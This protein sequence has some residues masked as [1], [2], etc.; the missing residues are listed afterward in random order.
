L[1]DEIGTVGVRHRRSRRRTKRTSA[2]DGVRNYQ[3]RNMLRDEFAIGDLAFFYHSSCD[4]PGI[5]GIVEVTSRG[6]PDA[7]A[8]DRKHANYDAASKPDDPRWYVVD[9]PS[10]KEIP[11]RDHARRITRTRTGQAARSF[12]SAARQSTLDHTGRGC[13]LEIHHRDGVRAFSSE[14]NHR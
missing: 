1:A 4:V 10:A 7:T 9:D 3:V 6:Y 14:R 13:A 12:D 5:A 8:F 11:A 2:W